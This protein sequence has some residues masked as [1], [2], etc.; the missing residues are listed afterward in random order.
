MVMIRKLLFA[1]VVVLVLPIGLA[2]AGVRVGIGIGL[3]LAAP[4]PYYGPYY[5][6]Y[7]TPYYYPYPTFY[8][9][10]PVYAGL[11][12]A[13]VQPAQAPIYVLPQSQLYPLPVM[14]PNVTP[15]S[16]STPAPQD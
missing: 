10:P 1:A 13:Y 7:Y 12:P 8:A 3:P 16:S 15:P 2:Q 4:A 6:P 14:Q 5:R 11:V 9:A